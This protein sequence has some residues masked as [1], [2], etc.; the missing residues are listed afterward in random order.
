MNYYQN[1]RLPMTAATL[2]LLLLSHSPQ[3]DVTS[4]AE[5]NFSNTLLL[6]SADPLYIADAISKLRLQSANNNK[7]KATLELGAKS[8]SYL[9]QE[10]SLDRAF[11]KTRTDRY[12]ITLGKTR[13]SWGEGSAFNAGDVIMGGSDLNLQL[14]ENDYRNSATW[15]T[16]FYRAT[17]RFSFTE[18]VIMPPEIQADLNESPTLDKAKV[19]ARTQFRVD[20]LAKTKFELGYALKG[21]H[22]QP[23]ISLQGGS[24]LNWHLSANLQADHSINAS[25]GVYTLSNLGEQY[26][27]SF[28]SELLY[29]SAGRS[30][31]IPNGDNYRTYA[32]AY[33]EFGLSKGDGQ[34]YY[35]RN[36]I[37]PIDQSAMIIL[38]TNI[39][40]HQGLNLFSHVS[41][42]QGNSDDT[43][44]QN[45]IGSYSLTLG[46]RFVF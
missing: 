24:G 44:K 34:S 1:K 26:T 2:V 9:E 30:T 36:I 41:M 46:S 45:L 33:V 19:A 27:L 32:Y 11:I 3:A 37:S 15:L 8:S 28:R 42:Q 23:Y 20:R 22:H 17:G 31:E 14:T 18:L 13:L 29:K 4:N 10:V 21:T 40:L 6:G 43:F 39:N 12:R 25:A 16:S 35:N 5:L 38:G 7:V